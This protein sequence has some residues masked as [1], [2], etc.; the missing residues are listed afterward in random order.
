MLALRK[1]TT[2]AHFW[3]PQPNPK[4]SIKHLPPVTCRLPPQRQPSHINQDDQAHKEGR[5]DVRINIINMSIYYFQMLTSSAAVNTVPGKSREFSTRSIRTTYDAR[6]SIS[7]KPS[8]ALVCA[9]QEEAEFMSKRKLLVTFRLWSTSPKLPPRRN[10]PSPPNQSWQ[11][12]IDA[13]LRLPNIATRRTF[14]N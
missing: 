6:D 13:T 1:I 10:L 3:W 11:N 9:W 2:P 8:K 7:R 4:S 5:C 12:E 14:E